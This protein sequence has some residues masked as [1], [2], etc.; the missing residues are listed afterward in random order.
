MHQTPNIETRKLLLHELGLAS[1]CKL[2]PV[3][4]SFKEFLGRM[5]FGIWH[6]VA[7]DV[8]GWKFTA[9][10]AARNLRSDACIYLD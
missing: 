6:D 8:D 4:S 7:A 9:Q 2:T 3:L 10:Y 1:G 5:A